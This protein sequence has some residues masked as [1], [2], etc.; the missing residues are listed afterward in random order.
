MSFRTYIIVSRSTLFLSTAIALHATAFAQ[1]SDSEEPQYRYQ[2]DLGGHVAMGFEAM[3]CER[4]D[5]VHSCQE[6]TPVVGLNLGAQYRLARRFAV[7]AIGGL[8]HD[9]SKD[10]GY[11]LLWRATAEGRYYPIA[12]GSTDLWL[13]LEAGLVGVT[14]SLPEK[15]TSGEPRM[16]DENLFGFGLG[17][18]V[19]VD[20]EIV[21]R[22]ALG[23]VLRT[24]GTF[25]NRSD[26]GY[27]GSYV[28]F[29]QVIWV[30]PGINIRYRI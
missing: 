27:L 19:G 14:A 20:F 25:T 16:V 3:T 28:D 13:S 12:H 29:S 2:I 5:D 23:I 6:P 15:R 7:G 4:N 9:P 22:L 10:T 18:N 8:S 17:L 11:V 24:L 30:M 1:E 26:R 21:E